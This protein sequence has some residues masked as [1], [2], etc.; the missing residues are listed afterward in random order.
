MHYLNSNSLA[1][2]NE[3]CLKFSSLFSPFAYF[4]CKPIQQG[5][6]IGSVC[7][8]L[9]CRFILKPDT[10]YWLSTSYVKR[11]GVLQQLLLLNKNI[12]DPGVKSVSF[13]P[14]YGSCSRATLQP[15]IFSWRTASRRRHIA[16][17]YPHW[18]RFTSRAKTSSNQ[19]V[20][21][22][23]PRRLFKFDLDP[24]IITTSG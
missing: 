19:Q 8:L 4:I 22:G 9:L 5:W 23:S 2:A 13:S 10:S 17:Y 20:P 21:C 24:R 14:S 6:Q 15:S 3:P 11:S 18:P 12:R 16:V 7:Q 1:G